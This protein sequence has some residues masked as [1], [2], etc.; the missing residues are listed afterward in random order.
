MTFSI[1]PIIKPTK[2][3]ISEEAVPFGLLCKTTEKSCAH[4]RQYQGKSGLWCEAEQAAVS[5]TGKL[6]HINLSE[7]VE[8]DSDSYLPVVIK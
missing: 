5:L 8:A 6:C 7:P 2:S 4:L 3:A 1:I